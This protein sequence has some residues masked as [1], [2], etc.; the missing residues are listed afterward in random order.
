MIFNGFRQ[1]CEVK[2][3]WHGAM[4][5][6]LGGNHWGHV[7][8]GGS[9]QFGLGQ[10]MLYVPVNVAASTG[11]GSKSPL[12][13]LLA[14]LRREFSRFRVVCNRDETVYTKYTCKPT[15]N[16]HDL[17][18]KTIH[19]AKFMPTGESHVTIAIYPQLVK[20]VFSK[21]FGRKTTREE[22]V[23]FLKTVKVSGVP[24]FDGEIGM[25]M[26]V[27]IKEPTEIIFGVST[28]VDGNP[29]VA[30]IEAE[31][32]GMSDV[33]R[34][35]GIAELPGYKTHLTIGYAHALWDLPSPDKRISD[36]ANKGG[37]ARSG[38]GHIMKAIH[39]ASYLQQNPKHEYYELG[40][41]II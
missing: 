24:L 16:R 36:P 38:P 30:L 1:F 22:E 31:C 11:G 28:F 35:L 26:P 37:S 21:H 41:M 8:Y 10:P 19:T 17:S 5:P 3:G 34:A 40:R 4:V 14:K 32:Q 29:I 13:K 12:G 15:N 6:F 39:N 33:K 27:R 25:E 2:F 20:E 18:D 9:E 7:N 23:Q